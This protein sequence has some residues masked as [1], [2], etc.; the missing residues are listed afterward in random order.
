MRQMQYSSI[1][2]Y[3]Y[4]WQNDLNGLGKYDRAA[5]IGYTAGTYRGIGPVCALFDGVNDG[6]GCVVQLPGLVEVFNKRREALGRAGQILDRREAGF[7]YDDSGLPSINVL[8]RFHY[9]TVALSFPAL[10]DLSDAGRQWINYGEYTASKTSNDRLVKVPYLFCSD[11][12][13]GG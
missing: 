6:D 3:G 1:M 8:E 13:S 7:S 4:N 5:I 11:E 9:T 12:W 10:T 2:D